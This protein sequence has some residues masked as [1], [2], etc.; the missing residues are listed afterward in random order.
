MEERKLGVLQ[1]RSC[2]GVFG[3]R[4]VEITGACRKLHKEGIHNL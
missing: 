3:I 1:K 4:R 2:R